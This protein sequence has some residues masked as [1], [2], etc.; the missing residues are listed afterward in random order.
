MYLNKKKNVQKNGGL[1]K[2][3]DLVLWAKLGTGRPA[4]KE[5]H[6]HWSIKNYLRQTD[7]NLRLISQYIFQWFHVWTEIRVIRFHYAHTPKLK[8]SNFT[9]K[10]CH[11]LKFE[12][13]YCLSSF[14]EIGGWT[15]YV[16]VTEFL[17]FACSTLVRPQVI[18]IRHSFEVYFFSSR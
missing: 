4:W 8:V 1:W 18:K 13:D 3:N 16:V 11:F 15:K 2:S 6:K 17:I 10:N 9:F 5:I 12:T 7:E 14:Q